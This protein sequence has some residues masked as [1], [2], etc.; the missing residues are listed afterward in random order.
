MNFSGELNERSVCADHFLDKELQA[1]IK[2][3][4]HQGCCSYCHER[5]M[6]M[7]VPDFLEMVRAKIN[8][9]FDTK[10]L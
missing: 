6:V 2:N 7:D 3:E 8:S 4:G 5:A 9:E 1:I 10:A